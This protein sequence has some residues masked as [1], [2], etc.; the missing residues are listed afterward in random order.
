MAISHIVWY[1]AY[2]QLAGIDLELVL[3]GKGGRADGPSIVFF[4]CFLTLDMLLPLEPLQQQIISAVIIYWEV[5]ASLT[6]NN[7]ISIL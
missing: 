6:N 5:S 1:G 4:T 2:R 3:V 7:N